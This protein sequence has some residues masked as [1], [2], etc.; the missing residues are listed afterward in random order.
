MTFIKLSFFNSIDD[1]KIT[2]LQPEGTCTTLRVY[3]QESNSDSVKLFFRTESYWPKPTK[4]VQP[5]TRPNY[6]LKLVQRLL[7]CQSSK[8]LALAWPWESLLEESSRWESAMDLLPLSP[9]MLLL[10]SMRCTLRTCCRDLIALGSCH[11]E[12]FWIHLTASCQE[13]CKS[14][15]W[16]VV[17]PRRYGWGKVK[18]GLN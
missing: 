18:L 7:K 9:T 16:R 13:G 1:H 10:G 5:S 3:A 2:P 6:G 8:M 11:C 17:I 15:T 14:S 4:W 12:P